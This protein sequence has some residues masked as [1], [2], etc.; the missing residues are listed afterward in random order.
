M[1]R[2]LKFRAWDKDS[3]K[4]CEVANLDWWGDPDQASCDLAGPG[5]NGGWEKLFY[6]D[7]GEVELMQYTGLK[8]KNGREIYEGDIIQEFAGE[9]AQGVWEYSNVSTV[10]DLRWLPDSLGFADCAYVIGNIYENPELE[11]VMKNH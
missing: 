1:S 11:A 5:K 8:D 10:E 7:V 3:R 6:I 2:Q 9:H 4:M